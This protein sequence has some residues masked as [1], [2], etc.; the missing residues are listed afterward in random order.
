M[1]RKIFLRVKAYKMKFFEFFAELLL[2]KI[3]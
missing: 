3:R 2:T 1:N